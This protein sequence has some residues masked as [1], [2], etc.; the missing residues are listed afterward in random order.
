MGFRIPQMFYFKWLFIISIRSKSY[1]EE[2][3]EKDIGL[4]KLES[5]NHVLRKNDY[6]ETFSKAIV[7]PYGLIF[8]DNEFYVMLIV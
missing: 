5:S 3:I 6:L 8:D 4:Q 7:L 1:I 2:F